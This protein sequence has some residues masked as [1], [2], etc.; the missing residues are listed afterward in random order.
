MELYKKLSKELHMDFSI[1]RA[2]LSDLERKVAVQTIGNEL[3]Y[4]DAA[5]LLYVSPDTV[6]RAKKRVMT[7]VTLYTTY[8]S[9]YDNMGWWYEQ[10]TVLNIPITRQT[11]RV[12]TRLPLSIVERLYCTTHTPRDVG[13]LK[14]A[15]KKEEAE[16]D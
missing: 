6:R 12:W 10:L 16:D 1:A 15:I 5:M 13:Q 4:R 9:S 11:M 8:M 2:Y 3:S 7:K 14:L